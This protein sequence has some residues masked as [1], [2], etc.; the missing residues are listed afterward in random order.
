M[1]EELKLEN[2]DIEMVAIVENFFTIDVDKKCHEI[3]FVY[4][5]ML[6]K[7]LDV[8]IFTSD[9][10]NDGYIYIKIEDI[11]RHNIRPKVMKELFKNKKSFVH[12][13]NCE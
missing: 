13:I 4:K 1:F 3:N 10:G 7:P 8:S 2:V 9:N 12:L 6:S 11:E 5:A